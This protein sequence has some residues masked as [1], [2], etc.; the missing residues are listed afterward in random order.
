MS[1]VIRYINTVEESPDNYK[2]VI[3]ESLSGISEIKDPDSER[4]QSKILDFLKINE[5]DISKC[6][7]QD[8]AVQQK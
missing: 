3:S 2:T 6:R 4:F 8:N 7:D 5:I 1:V